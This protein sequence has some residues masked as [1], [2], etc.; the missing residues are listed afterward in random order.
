MFSVIENGQPVAKQPSVSYDE[1]G[2]A[3]VSLG[4]YLTDS[5]S[6]GKTHGVAC[7]HSR[8]YLLNPQMY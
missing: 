4:Q 7:F 6:N 1:G 2:S 3:Q 8:L 5:D